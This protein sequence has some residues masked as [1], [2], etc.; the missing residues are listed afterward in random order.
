MASN[1]KQWS[2]TDH[3]STYSHTVKSELV[4]NYNYSLCY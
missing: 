1:I 4:L 3:T 2:M